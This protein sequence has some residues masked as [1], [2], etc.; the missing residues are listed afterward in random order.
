MATVNQVKRIGTRSFLV[1][2]MFLTTLCCA[3]V[4]AVYSGANGNSVWLIAG[5]AILAVGIVGPRNLRIPFAPLPWYLVCTVFF[6]IHRDLFGWG[7]T[8]ISSFTEETP[9]AMQILKDLVW[10]LF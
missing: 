7:P 6:Y 9:V 2:A 10:V 1:P 8:D 4:L 3:L 5:I